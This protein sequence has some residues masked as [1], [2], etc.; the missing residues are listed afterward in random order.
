MVMWISFLCLNNVGQSSVLIHAR[1]QTC[2]FTFSSLYN[3]HLIEA[4]LR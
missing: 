3:S 1:S 2:E 4:H